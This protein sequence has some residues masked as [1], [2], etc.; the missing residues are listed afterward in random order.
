M[1]QTELKNHIFKITLNRPEVRNALNAELIQLITQKLKS[2][3]K[4][5]DAKVILIE[6]KGKAFSSGA[7]LKWLKDI[8]EFSYQENFQDSKNFVELLNTINFHPKPIITKINGAAIGG[9]AGIALSSD[10]IIASDNSFFGIS[11]VAIG[12]IPAAIIHLVKQRIGETKAREYLITGERIPALEAHQI[13]MINYCVKKEE[14]ENKTNSLIEILLKNGPQAIA[15]VKEMIRRVDHLYG[16]DLDDYISKTIAELRI[17][18]EGSEG[19]S[20]FLEKR[21]PSWRD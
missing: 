2:I 1:I 6:G 5:D 3:E 20:A 16:E 8:S 14:L 18:N 12:I 15:K 10:I 4:N 7:D 11:E 13:G 17:S 9:G 19:I 21:K